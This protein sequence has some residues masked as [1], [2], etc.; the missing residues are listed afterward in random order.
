[1]E[2][3]LSNFSAQLPSDEVAIRLDVN[4]HLDFGTLQAVMQL[5]MY[6]GTS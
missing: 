6:K 4:Q 2:Q 3:G 1:L 5:Q